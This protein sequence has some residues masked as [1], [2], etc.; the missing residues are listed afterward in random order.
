M[1][2]GD[3][4][5]ERFDARVEARSSDDGAVHAVTASTTVAMPITIQRRRGRCSK[6]SP[7]NGVG[8]LRCHGVCANKNAGGRQTLRTSIPFGWVKPAGY[9]GA[10]FTIWSAIS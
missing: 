8:T 10:A 1:G 4:M 2:S 7:R 5:G 3:A 9:M 6:R